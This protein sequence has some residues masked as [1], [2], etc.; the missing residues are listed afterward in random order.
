MSLPMSAS[1]RLRVLFLVEGF[2]D[3]RFVVGLSQICD[4]TMIVP[5]RPFRESGLAERVAESGA[6]LRVIEI[7]GGRLRFQIRVDARALAAGGRMRS[8]SVAGGAARLAQ[9]QHHR[10]A[11]QDSRRHL[12]GY[13][14][15]RVFSLP[16]RTPSDRAGHVV[17]GEHAHSHAGDHQRPPGNSLPRH[18][19]VPPRRRVQVVRED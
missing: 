7:P 1:R 5:S 9:R 6:T 19:A 3:I 15:A 12:H 11:S 2:T 13:L 16:A 17:A 4:L 14:A 10:P 8:D 18:G